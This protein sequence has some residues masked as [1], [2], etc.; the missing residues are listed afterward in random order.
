VVPSKFLFPYHSLMFIR[1][2]KKVDPKNQKHY[3]VYQLVEAY[4]T[5]KGPRQRILLSLDSEIGIADEDL[6]LLSNRIE[7]IFLGNPSL[8]V[9]CAE[10]ENLAQKYASRLIQRLSKSKTDP[11]T[12][13]S[14]TPDY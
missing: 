4:R 5:D 13:G 2:T 10:I 6:K 7:D 3:F 12:P 11:E 9:P 14:K 8:F 1:K